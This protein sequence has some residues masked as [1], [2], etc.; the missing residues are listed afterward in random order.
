[1]VPFYRYVTQESQ[2]SQFL[3]F[4]EGRALLTKG[5]VSFAR[6]TFTVDFITKE[7]ESVSVCNVRNYSIQDWIYL[8]YVVSSPDGV[9]VG[10]DLGSVLLDLPNPAESLVFLDGLLL[11]STQYTISSDTLT[12]PS[13]QVGESVIILGSKTPG[14]ISVISSFRRGAAL[15]FDASG[16]QSVDASGTTSVFFSNSNT[17]YFTAQDSQTTFGFVDSLGTRYITAPVGLNHRLYSNFHKRHVGWSVVESRKSGLNGEALIVNEE[18]ASVVSLF[19]DMSLLAPT[20]GDKVTVIPNPVRNS[21]IQRETGT[22]SEVLVDGTVNVF[23]DTSQVEVNV[24]LGDIERA[25][26]VLY[27]APPPRKNI[28]SYLTPRELKTSFIP[29]IMESFQRTILDPIQ[30]TIDYITNI[31]DTTYLNELDFQKSLRLRGF[32]LPVSAYSRETA[33]ALDALLPQLQKARGSESSLLLLNLIT[34]NGQLSEELWTDDYR[35]FFTRGD[36]GVGQTPIIQYFK[37]DYLPITLS[38]INTVDYEYV[39]LPN[40]E[41]VDYDL[42]TSPDFVVLGLQDAGEPPAPYYPTNHV[43]LTVAQGKEIT[44]AD[45]R[46]LEEMF[47]KLAPIE[48]L[49]YGTVEEL[50]LG[51]N[52]TNLVGSE[53]FVSEE[54]IM[55]SPIQYIEGL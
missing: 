40:Q 14:N 51:S 1:M 33:I 34:V 44:D 9:V 35:N 18:E 2:D 30:S 17:Y 55:A 41:L 43:V 25:S 36:L 7:G 22:I 5:L 46:I 12:I 16:T 11:N 42:I 49:L 39:S 32:D 26:N 53:I 10:Y 37:V 8:E 28:A 20:S 19:S 48:L 47:Y 21:V 13:A 6:N 38:A 3:L 4:H 24:S 52:T 23:L 50:N 29:D 54:F 27:I 45:Y 31:R 15:Y